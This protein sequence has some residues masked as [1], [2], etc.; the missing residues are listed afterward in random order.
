MQVEGKTR[1]EERR[2]ELR[3]KPKEESR[4]RRYKGR[5]W[6]GFGT[7]EREE[8][9]EGEEREMGEERGLR[10]WFDERDNESKNERKT[11]DFL[12]LYTLTYLTF[13]KISF[14]NMTFVNKV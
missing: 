4:W 11:H 6:L 8:R 2:G 5:G 14:D 12:T 13:F 10:V 1:R 3:S 7:S 9:T